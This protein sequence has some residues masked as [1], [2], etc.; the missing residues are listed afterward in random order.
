MAGS[1]CQVKDKSIL[2][3]KYLWKLGLV[4][5]FPKKVLRRVSTDTPS[6]RRSPEIQTTNPFDNVLTSSP[7]NVPALQTANKA[8]NE[9]LA[10]IP[11]VPSPLRKFVRRLTT[12][13]ER[14]ETRIGVVETE[15]ANCESVLAVRK[16]RGSGKRGILKDRHSVAIAEVYEGVRTEE[17][18]IADAKAKR[19]RKT[20]VGQ[21]KLP[22]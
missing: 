15:K 13:H 19:G 20:G 8:L 1:V 6:P 11:G 9:T 4:P 2:Y 22:M 18:R 14:L 5:F 21:L 12:Q 3:P 16:K 7:I 10:Q 17:K